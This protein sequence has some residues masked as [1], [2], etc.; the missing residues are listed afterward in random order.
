M[1]IRKSTKK[2]N[3]QGITENGDGTFTTV[4][5]REKRRVLKALHEQGVAVRSKQNTDGTWTVTPVGSVRVKAQPRTVSPAPAPY[6]EPG[7]RINT[8]ESGFPK[9]PRGGSG[10]PTPRGGGRPFPGSTGGPVYRGGPRASGPSP[11]TVIGNKAGEYL[12]ERQRKK[13]AEIKR[14][15][16]LKKLS[17]EMSEKWNKEETEKQTKEQKEEDQRQMKKDELRRQSMGQ[18]PGDLEK[19]LHQADVKAE[20]RRADDAV[21]RQQEQRQQRQESRMNQGGYTGGSTRAPEIPKQKVDPA[22]LQHARESAV[23]GED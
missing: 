2:F 5:K 8:R 10:R 13:E 18:Q 9:Y 16:E 17:D 12:R 11:L 4:G 21:R 7:R 3:W 14:Q 1:V 15:Q 6:R 19:S 23:K 22:T 20:Q